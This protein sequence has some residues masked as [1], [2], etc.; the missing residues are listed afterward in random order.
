M[1]IYMTKN[2]VQGH[3]VTATLGIET[4]QL[5]FTQKY[6]NSV[7]QKNC[8]SK[9]SSSQLCALRNMGSPFCHFLTSHG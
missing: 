1:Y 5:S 3:T 2:C 4:L 8:E 9:L 6:F 7:H